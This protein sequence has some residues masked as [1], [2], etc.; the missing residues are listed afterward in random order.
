MTREH[1]L[2]K[3]CFAPLCS[4]PDDAP[5][6]GLLDDTALLPAGRSMD[7]LL[8]SD[9]LVADRHFFAHDPAAAIARKALA[10]NVYDIVAKGGAPRSYLLSIALPAG[11]PA[12][13]L[14][15]FADGLAKAQKQYGCELIGGDTVATDGPLVISITLLGEVPSGAM[16]RRNG[17]R[18]G[19]RLYVSGA[20]GDAALG[21]LLRREDA[22]IA[23]LELSDAQ[24]SHLLNAY[25]YPA[26]SVGLA[27]ALLRHASAAM[28][29]SDGLLGDA[30]K[31]FAVSECGAR[32]ETGQV[33]LSDAATRLLAQNPD[34]LDTVLTG[35]DD[36]RV[37]ATVPADRVAEFEAE[38]PQMVCIGA[39]VPTKEGVTVLDASGKPLDP[40]LDLAHG[41]YDHFASDRG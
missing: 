21:L 14:Q 17:A 31:L 13:W 34:L 7:Q 18:A 24:R 30:Q 9:M 25:L 40:A 28:D 41:A 10:V 27:P 2:I 36:Y 22:K 16:V 1:D 4:R 38:A 23:G 32:I 15:Q 6:F 33:P 39:I 37:L 8:T 19:D 26:P 5:A 11:L 3:R 29:V 20:I 12:D 35:G